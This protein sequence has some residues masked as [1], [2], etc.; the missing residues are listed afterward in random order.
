LTPSS[1]L[2]LLA[3]T[4]LLKAE[5]SPDHAGLSEAFAQDMGN[6]LTGLA[7]DDFDPLAT[8]Q[9]DL[10]A[11]F[12]GPDGKTTT[13]EYRW[14]IPWYPYAVEFA[15]L[16][17]DHLER[18]HAGNANMVEAR[19]VLAKLVSRAQEVT[20]SRTGIYRGEYLLHLDS[21]H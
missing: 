13:G 1:G 17:I 4:V 16:W 12:T 15:Q 18:I 7:P 20:G 2:T 19:R 8:E 10:R 9:D 21:V 11:E 6:R 3:Y 5:L 14:K